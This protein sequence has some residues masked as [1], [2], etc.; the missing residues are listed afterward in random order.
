MTQWVTDIA[1]IFAETNT[2]VKA[3]RVANGLPALSP[4][5]DILI[6]QEFLAQEHDAP[7]IV[8]V[9]M[10]TKYEAGK[11]M[12]NAGATGYLPGQI[13]DRKFLFLRWLTFEAH[14]WGEPDPQYLNNAPTTKTGDALYDF[15]TT[16]ELERQFFS[17]LQ[18]SVTIP[19][20]HPLDGTWNQPTDVNRRGRE[21]TVAFRIGTPLTNEPYTQLPYSVTSGDG[22]V[23][24]HAYIT[25]SPANNPVGPEIIPTP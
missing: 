19:M 2:A 17:S 23:I 21:L 11:P 12:Q 10:G 20:G 6:G 16:L 3:I 1:A 24:R 22:G 25:V 7:R 18:A 13:P 15:N 14:F 9:P 5:G 8:I 4:S